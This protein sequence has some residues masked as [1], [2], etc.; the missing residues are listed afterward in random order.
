MSV[1]N[2]GTIALN[3]GTNSVIGTST[4]FKSHVSVGQFIQVPGL[5]YVLAIAAVLDDFNLTV[6]QI[7]PG[8]AGNTVG[9]LRYSIAT[10]FT[11]ILSMPLPGPHMLNSQDVLNRNWKIL[12][13]EIPKIP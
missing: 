1:Y 7:I 5:P 11:P 12:D 8:P 4:L 9:G 2:A 10:Y 6:T 13:T 3:C